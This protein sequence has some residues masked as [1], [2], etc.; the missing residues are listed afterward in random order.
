MANSITEL[1]RHLF[2]ALDRLGNEELKGDELKQEVARAQ[3][4]AEVATKAIDNAN[5]ALQVLRMEANAEAKGV[6]V[7]VRSL[8]G[9][10]R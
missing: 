4:V 6:A 8:L 5:T 2:A 10:G 1:N 9:T 3:A 7:N